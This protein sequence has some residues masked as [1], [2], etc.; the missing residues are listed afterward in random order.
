MLLQVLDD[1]RMTDGQGRTV[2]FKNTVIVMTSNLG[3]SEIQQMAGSSHEEIKDAVMA[4][5]KAH[6]RPEFINRIDEIVVFNALD[7][8]AI[9]RIAKIQIDKLA[10][11]VEAQ[12]LHLEVTDAALSAVA[13]AGFDPLYGARPLKRAVQEYI[14]NRVARMLLEGKCMPKD[15]I[16]VDADENGNFSFSTRK[17]N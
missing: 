4:Q 3:A 7:N 5:V 13:R 1:G 2:D 16:V 14:E 11:R 6:F 10:A 17:P 8:E 12:D 15:A 9:R